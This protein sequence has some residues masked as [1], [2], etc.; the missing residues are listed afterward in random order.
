MMNIKWAIFLLI[1]VLYSSYSLADE[2][3]VLEKTAQTQGLF[4]FYSSSCQHCQQFAPILKRFSDRYGFKVLPI[5]VD[6][7]FLPSFP[8]AV[9]DEGQRHTFR[10]STL[11]SL[12]L[13]NPHNQLVALITEGAIS[14][15]ELINRLVKIVSLQT[16]EQ[17]E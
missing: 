5:S 16:R 10:V 17:A 8:D 7:G 4:F 2:A 13:V 12:F 15:G 3:L 11:P 9:M 6:G 14:E 1:G